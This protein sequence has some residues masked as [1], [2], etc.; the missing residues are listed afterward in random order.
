MIYLA[1]FLGGGLGS[2]M[3][4]G[5]TKLGNQIFDTDLPTGTILS[6]IIAC[7][8]LALAVTAFRNDV[9]S[10]TF[11]TNFLLIGLC[12]GYSTFSTF[13]METVQLIQAGNTWAAVLNVL[14]SLATCIGLIYILVRNTQPA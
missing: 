12:G 3:R 7:L 5:T 11:F 13:S 10:S 6:N 8:I 9:K 2:L 4:F 1:I 14:I